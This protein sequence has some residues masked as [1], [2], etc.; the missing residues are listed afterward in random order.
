MPHRNPSL[1]RRGFY[2]H[3]PNLEPHQNRQQI[4]VMSRVLRGPVLTGM[5]GTCCR[6]SAVISQAP[7]LFPRCCSRPALGR[8]SRAPASASPP[9]PS[10]PPCTGALLLPHP[11]HLGSPE[12]ALHRRAPGRTPTSPVPQAQSPAGHARAEHS[13][14]AQPPV[15]CFGLRRSRS[16]TPQ[17]SAGRAGRRAGR[18]GSLLSLTSRDLPKA[19]CTRRP[20]TSISHALPCAPLSPIPVI[21]GEREATAALGSRQTGPWKGLLRVRDLGGAQASQHLISQRCPPDSPLHCRTG[22]TH[23][24]LVLEQGSISGR[25]P[26]SCSSSL[27]SPGPRTGVPTGELV[28]Q[29]KAS[30]ERGCMLDTRCISW[31]SQTRGRHG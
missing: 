11:M 27:T 14:G 20:R 13:T 18:Q 12:A 26:Y 25:C 5:A 2:L 10:W 31:G 9:A 29:R 30:R 17:L 6:P 3:R 28:G 15:S 8:R 7:S 16:P 24:Y 23:I 4:G 1:L 22:Q 21:P 19:A